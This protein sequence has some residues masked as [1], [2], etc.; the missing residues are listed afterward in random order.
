MDQGYKGI[1]MSAQ[2]DTI[3]VGQ[4]LGGRHRVISEGIPHDFGMLYKV[5]DMRRDQMAE[6]LIVARRFGSGVDVLDRV[7][8]TNRAVKDLQQPN[9]IPFEHAGLISGQVFLVR[10]Q[11]P[12][13]TLA[14]LLSQDGSMNIE[15]GVDIATRLCETLMPLHRAG[16]VHG[17]LSPQCVLVRVGSQNLATPENPASAPQPLR[18]V[19]VLDV[20]LLPAL[21]SSDAPPGVPWGRFP[22]L[23]PEQAAGE[24]IHSG[25]DVYVV[26]SLLYE[27]LSGRPP[28]RSSD[29]MILAL[30][31][32]RQDPPSLQVLVPG[33]PLALI[34]ILQ[35]AL[36]KEPAA[37]YRNAGQL[38][39]ILHAQVPQ[40][41]SSQLTSQA[42]K[43]LVVPPP[44]SPPLVAAVPA[45]QVVYDDGTGEDYKREGSGD[46]DWVMVGLIVAAL[47]AVLGL[48]LLW[49][50][51]YER[52]TVPPVVPASSS[53]PLELALANH[54]PQLA[55]DHLVC[56]NLEL[57]EI[58]WLARCPVQNRSVR[59]PGAPM[60]G[61][62]SLPLFCQDPASL[63]VQ[64]TGFWT[65]L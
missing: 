40:M 47:V 33:A 34:Q 65:N 60:L 10:D 27:M 23:S 8:R 9:L 62:R 30:Q 26:G 36:A 21:R 2:D 20:G 14:G 41:A 63:G 24:D 7:I 18:T 22:Y 49:R 31:H 28:F 39:Y 56:Y 6:A 37:R 32:L 43:Q 53:Y 58:M 42:Q 61:K 3:Q 51:V 48:I 59:R 45:T 38:A 19:S 55:Q 44:P 57:P 50:T 15:A 52:Y 1:Q 17:G 16:M 13:R 4:V 35:K 29:E 5:Y 25:S 54:E 46:V 12:G 64:L 11:V